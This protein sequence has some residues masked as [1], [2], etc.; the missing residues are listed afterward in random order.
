M[1]EYV[2]V[3]RSRVVTT[4]VCVVSC[5][6]VSCR[7]VSCRVVS[8]SRNSFQAVTQVATLCSRLCHLKGEMLLNKLI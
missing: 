2:T 3:Y 8:F 1:S 5:R 7:V 4:Y 6:V